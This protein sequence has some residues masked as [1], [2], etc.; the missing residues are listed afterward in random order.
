[1]NNTAAVTW[2]SFHARTYVL[3]G[4]TNRGVSGTMNW[5]NVVTTAPEARPWNYPTATAT[6]VFHFFRVLAQPVPNW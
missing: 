5:S 1:T 6:N 3:Q 2:P 4:S